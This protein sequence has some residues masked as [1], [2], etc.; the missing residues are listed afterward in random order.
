MAETATTTMITIGGVSVDINKP[1]DVLTELRKAELVIGVGE[2]VSMARFGED[3]T[4]FTEASLPALQKLIAQYEAKCDRASG[5]RRRY[6]AGI[7]FT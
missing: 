4:R 1:C 7:Q 2:A 6:A 3:E 5:R